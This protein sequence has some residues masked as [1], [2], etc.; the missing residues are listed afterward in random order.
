MPFSQSAAEALAKWAPDGRTLVICDPEETG[1]YKSFRNLP[2]V[3][4]LPAGAAGVADVIGHPSIAVSAAALEV[5]ES[6]AADV[7][8]GGGS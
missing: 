4:V 3:T 5:L 2:G 6:R 7:T 8:R 1:V